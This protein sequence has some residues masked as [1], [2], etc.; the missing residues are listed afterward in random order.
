MSTEKQVAEI[1]NQVADLLEIKGVE[2]K[3]RAYRRAARQVDSL[4]DDLEEIHSRGE[5]EEI[6]SVGEKIAEKIAEILETGK[7]EY[8]EELKEEIPIDPVLLKVRN[9]GPKKM[10]KIWEELD[11]T[12]LD[13]LEEAGENQ[14]IR[15]IKGFGPKSE[16]NIMKGLEI[17]RRS[18]GKIHISEVMPVATEIRDQMEE[19]GSFDDIGFAGSLRRRKYQVGDV[20][21]LATTGDRGEA[22]DTFSAL[23]LVDQVL[24][25]GDTKASIRTNEGLRIDL[26]IVDRASLGAAKQYF[27]GSQQHNVRMRQRAI[28]R[29]YKLNEYGLFDK[30]SEEKVSGD[31]EAEIYQKL[32]LSWIPPE[33]REARGEIGVAENDRLPRLVEKDEIKGDLH[34]HSDRSS[35]GEIPLETLGEQ[36]Q[37]RGYSYLTVTDHAE[38]AGIVG[39]LTDEDVDQHIEEIGRMNEE[40][41]GLQLFPGVEANVQ[42]DGSL[43]LSGKSL[44]KLDIVLAG[45]HSGF[46]MAESEMTERLVRAIENEKTDIIA[47]PTGRKLGERG[48]FDLDWSQVFSRARETDTALEINASPSR[49]DLHD[50]LIKRALENEIK[51]SIGTDSHRVSHLDF[52]EYG[53]Y[54]ARRGWCEPDDLLNTLTL[55]E[56]K[57]WL[58]D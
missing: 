6:P 33:L 19:S 48:S 40:L 47:H 34:C 51:L 57:D 22:M 3:P 41:E 11:V 13:E 26:R 37:K 5:L 27:T 55:P 21:I 49:T 10:K 52:M 32:G 1:L 25:K 29:G 24:S 20:D 30:D 35:D 31:D 36:A 44:E 58:Q 14:R 38:T 18:Q 28:A 53:V 9:L 2:Y 15:E 23:D 39:G 46:D 16:K 43:D 56:L 45:V 4:A 50:K 12:T 8:H 7:L 17:V 42:K 54:L